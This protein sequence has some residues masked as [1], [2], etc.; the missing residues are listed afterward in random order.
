MKRLA[1]LTLTMGLFLS[2]CQAEVP[3]EIQST[4]D[5]TF[6]V[7]VI[8]P[9]S[10]PNDSVPVQ[11]PPTAVVLPPTASI[12]NTSSPPPSVGQP[13]GIITP[14]NPVPSITP[15]AGGPLVRRSVPSPK[16]RAA[17]MKFTRPGPYSKLSSP[18]K[19]NALISPGD[20]RRLYVN[21]IG[22][23]GRLID[24]QILDFGNYDSLRFNITAEIPFKINSAA[25]LA[26]IEMYVVDQFDLKIQQITVD[27]ILIQYG[28]SEET[29]SEIELEPFIVSVPGEGT[30]VSGGVLVVEGIARTVT[31]G[32][33]I[34]DLVDERG[35]I[36][37]TGETH[38]SPPSE[39]NSH[40][41]FQVIVPYT[42]DYRTRVRLTVRQESTGRI[43]GTVWLSSSVIFLDP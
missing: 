40:M 42:V 18:I 12:S 21:L 11:L 14:G 33:L 28:D 26:R 19:I 22:E 20:D 38:V 43:P 2:A 27:V 41:P 30:I 8:V 31:D 9:P 39:R 5:P 10:Q 25:E 16:P 24:S 36:V 34:V 3:A 37:G 13:V 1:G 15:T 35:G 7:T 4:A 6:G 23:D 32:P 29:P 17:T